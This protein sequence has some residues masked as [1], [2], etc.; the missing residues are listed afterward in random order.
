[1]LL[2]K[3]F[4]SL[5]ENHEIEIS[6]FNDNTGWFEI[7]KLKQEECKTFVYLFREVLDFLRDNK[8][9]SIKQFVDEESV[10]FCK[11]SEINKINNNLYE[12]K[13]EISNFIDEIIVNLLGI[14]KI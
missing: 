1:M 12:I 8:I 9:S 7:I 5:D 11:L 4:V 10:K 3:K 2:N 13:T 14:N 6:I